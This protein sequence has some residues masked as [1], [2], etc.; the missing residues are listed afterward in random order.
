MLQKQAR[1][2]KIRISRQA[3]REFVPTLFEESSSVSK[4]LG[5]SGRKVPCDFGCQLE[6]LRFLYV[7][8]EPRH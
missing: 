7:G 3:S 1:E 5:R 6:E 8:N 2:H 4:S